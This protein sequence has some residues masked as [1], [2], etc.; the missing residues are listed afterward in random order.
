[1]QIILLEG[2]QYAREVESKLIPA[3]DTLADIMRNL[4]SL[5]A[6]WFKGLRPIEVYEE[7]APSPRWLLGKSIL[8]LKDQR[9]AGIDNRGKRIMIKDDEE[10]GVIIEKE[11]GIDHV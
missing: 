4:V 7:I 8:R 10:Q 1:M 6:Y 2:D 11:D 9:W 3:R 5:P